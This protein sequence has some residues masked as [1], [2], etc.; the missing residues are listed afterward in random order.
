MRKLAYCLL[1]AALPAHA[2]LY[3][4][5]DPQS[6]S[7]KFSNL[8]PPWYGDPLRQAG[9]PAVEVISY[10]SPVKP[11]PPPVAGEKPPPPRAQSGLEERWRG[12]LKVIAV[13][14]ERPD[15]DRAGQAIQ[16]QVQAYEAVRAE[17]DRMDPNG[18]A[19]RRAE[20]G[21]LFERLKK[22]LEAQFGR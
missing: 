13:L 20:E 14:P 6:G 15:F 10:G 2:D 5:V 1:L 8:P 21:G 4:W 17:L 3:R 12:L 22:G 18:A 11:A 9:S 7:V 16:Q 19:R